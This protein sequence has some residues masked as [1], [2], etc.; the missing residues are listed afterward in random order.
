MQAGVK[1]PP[2]DKPGDGHVRHR[3]ALLRTRALGPTSA[4]MSGQEVTIAVVD[5]AAAVA[6]AASSRAGGLLCE[7]RVAAWRRNRE[8]AVI[9]DGGDH[10]P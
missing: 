8:A 10:R 1:R 9:V 4:A 6:L 2:S 5:Q 3:G 7:H